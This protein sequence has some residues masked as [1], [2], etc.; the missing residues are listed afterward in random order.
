M[1][2]VSR[3]TPA[4]SPTV[5]IVVP[6][7]DEEESIPLF[8]RSLFAVI[9][10]L[11][12][13]FEVITVDDGSGDNSHALLKEAAAKRPELKVIRFV[14]NLGQTAAI[15]AGIDHAA[16]EII[17]NIDADLQNDPNDIPKLLDALA[18]DT[19]LVSGWRVNR[20]D[21]AVRRN[22]VSRIANRLISY[23][24]GVKLHDYGCTLKAYRKEVLQ[25]TRLYGEMHRFIPIYAFWMG[26]K[27]VEVPVRHHPRRFGSSK[28]GL[29]RTLKV[30]LDLLLIKFLSRYLVK[31]IYVFGGFGALLMGTSFVVLVYMLYLKY[32]EE[33]SMIQ[34]PLPIIFAMLLLIGV[35]SILLGILAEIVVRIYFESQGRPSYQIR[36]TTNIDRMV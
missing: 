25:G 33:I 30:L 2:V 20:Q 19:S 35:V 28:Y 11:P 3:V 6:I 21:A 31:P 16:G 36:E 34:T 26:A 9:D 10:Q 15:M 17:I 29:R 5:S 12:Y 8:L 18:G 22:F 27:I 7:Y 32:Y 23:V 14:R 1:P 4:T 24:S 13:C